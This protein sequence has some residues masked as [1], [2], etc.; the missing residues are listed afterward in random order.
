MSEISKEYLATPW[1]RF[2]AGVID[3]FP[4]MFLGLSYVF[5]LFLHGI[6][7][8][9]LDFR[10]LPTE[11]VPAIIR[12]G[13]WTA[14]F[15]FI[16]CVSV[17]P[18]LFLINIILMT[19]GGASVGKRVLKLKVV[20]EDR[21]HLTFRDVLTREVVG[22]FLSTIPFGIGY[23]GIIRD[24]YRQALHDQLTHTYVILRQY[25]EPAAW[26]QRAKGE[27]IVG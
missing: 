4:V 26:P 7:G 2:I 27:N 9:Q 22:R 3:H 18:L 20:H 24:P 1:Q 8:T 19:S 16:I 21:S 12:F 13:W 15:W 17:Y 11:L 6:T 23:V 14:G 25:A 5:V 10:S